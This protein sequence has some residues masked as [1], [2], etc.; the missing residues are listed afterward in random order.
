MPS[1][2]QST[3]LLASHHRTSHL[4]CCIPTLNQNLTHMCVRCLPSYR[5]ISFLYFSFPATCVDACFH[6]HQAIDAFH[7]IQRQVLSE[8]S[9]ARGDAKL[10]KRLRLDL[11]AI[12]MSLRS[13]LQQ[14]I[15]L[16][17]QQGQL[18]Q[19]CFLTLQAEQRLSAPEESFTGTMRSPLK[20]FARQAT[21]HPSPGE[22]REVRSSSQDTESD[23]R[24]S[25]LI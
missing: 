1:R 9:D 3:P 5:S 25:N 4:R 7:I 21:K 19:N 24:V 8:I 17:D 6:R 23:R 2:K 22:T 20:W 18:L 10:I 14:S 11:E 12:Y 13:E 16:N 15:M